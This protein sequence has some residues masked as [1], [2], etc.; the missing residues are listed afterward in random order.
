MPMQITIDMENAF[1]YMFH[2]GPMATINIFVHV[3]VLIFIV[4]LLLNDTQFVIIESAITN[5]SINIFGI[6]RTL[7]CIV[8]FF[9]CTAQVDWNAFAPSEINWQIFH[10]V[11]KIESGRIVTSTSLFRQLHKMYVWVYTIALAKRIEKKN[12][13]KKFIDDARWSSNKKREKNWNDISKNR[14]RKSYR[15]KYSSP[16]IHKTHTHSHLRWK[17]IDIIDYN[18]FYFLPCF[19][20]VSAFF[21][22]IFIFLKFNMMII[23][24]HIT[25]VYAV[26]AFLQ[27]V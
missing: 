23:I 19:I 14:R 8:F 20:S 9:S 26:V 22:F 24:G 25:V 1:R 5:N 15:N 18:L 4:C 7:F 21:I 3:P 2:I 13:P 11:H 16:T 17:W 27:R 10:M 12:H 6:L